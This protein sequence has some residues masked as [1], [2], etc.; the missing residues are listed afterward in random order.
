MNG[1]NI[2]GLMQAV[3]PDSTNLNDITTPGIYFRRNTAYIAELSQY[4]LWYA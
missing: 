1:Y 4:R 2:M 3:I